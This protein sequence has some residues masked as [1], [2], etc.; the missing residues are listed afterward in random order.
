[1]SRL[2]NLCISL[3]I[4]HQLSLRGAE[5]EEQKVQRKDGREARILP[6]RGFQRVSFKMLCIT[7]VAATTLAI[8]AWQ[9][10]VALDAI[11][12][13]PVAGSRNLNPLGTRRSGLFRPISGVKGGERGE[14]GQRRDNTS[15]MR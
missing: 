12:T 10:V 13:T 11:E 1:L 5:P 7:T 15:W 2:R 4:S 14:H 8:S 9:P 6:I 3:L